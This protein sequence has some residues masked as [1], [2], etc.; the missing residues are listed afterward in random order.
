MSSATDGLCDLN[1]ETMNSNTSKCLTYHRITVDDSSNMIGYRLTICPL[2]FPSCAG[3]SIASIYT[4]IYRLQ[5]SHCV[6]HAVGHLLANAAEASKDEMQMQTKT[7]AGP[8]ILDFEAAAFALSSSLRAALAE[9]GHP[10][11]GYPHLRICLKGATRAH[12]ARI[13]RRYFPD[14]PR[15]AGAAFARCWKSG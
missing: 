3:G 14:S 8:A 11:L 7:D 10:A 1:L 15:T 12:A 5:R 6:R 9:T 2:R 13:I 4:K